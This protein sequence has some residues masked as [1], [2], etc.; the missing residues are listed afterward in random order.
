MADRHQQLHHL[1][2]HLPLHHHHHHHHSCFIPE[3]SPPA[4]LSK[5]LPTPA[6]TTTTSSTTYTYMSAHMPCQLLS[7]LKEKH[8]AVQLDGTDL[9]YILQLGTTPSCGTSDSVGSRPPCVPAS[10]TAYA[11]R[12]LVGRLARAAGQQPTQQW[13][14][15]IGGVD[16]EELHHLVAALD[17]AKPTERVCAMCPHAHQPLLAVCRNSQR[18]PA[19]ATVSHQ[20][21]SPMHGVAGCSCTG[22]PSVGSLLLNSCMPPNTKALLPHITTE[23]PSRPPLSAGD[24][25]SAAQAAPALLL[26]GQTLSTWRLAYDGVPYKQQGIWS[27]PTPV[28]LLCCLSASRACTPWTG[29]ASAG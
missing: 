17:L 13:C 3:H 15:P 6:P 25:G 18:W 11:L 2:L 24:S 29:H 4:P 27:H 22:L 26:D 1:H 16:S 23:W 7:L 5:P 12:M 28:L 20:H 14:S 9:W 10:S 19:M 8:Q 21:H